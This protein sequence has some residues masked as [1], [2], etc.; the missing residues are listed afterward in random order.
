MMIIVSYSIEFILHRYYLR[1]Y[2]YVTVN[3]FVIIYK[4]LLKN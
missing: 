1:Y 2:L 4:L 3:N